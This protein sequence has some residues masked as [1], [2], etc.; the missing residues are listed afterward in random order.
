MHVTTASDQSSNLYHVGYNYR[1]QVCP[2]T[3]RA[4]RRDEVS[5]TR[6]IYGTLY[7]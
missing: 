1:D 6:C 2:E 4:F 3:F 5:N 7:N